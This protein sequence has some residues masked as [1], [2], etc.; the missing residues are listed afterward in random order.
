[1]VKDRN[2]RVRYGG[3][4]Q[5]GIP[6]VNSFETLNYSRENL[7]DFLYEFFEPS[8]SENAFF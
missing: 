7:Q 1:M 3:G 5:I 6:T 8:S 4:E 2:E